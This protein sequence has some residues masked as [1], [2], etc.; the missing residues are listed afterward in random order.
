MVF[1]GYMPSS[2]IAGS[3]G[4]SIFGTVLKSKASFAFH[5]RLKRMGNITLEA[6][7]P[8]LQNQ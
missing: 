7:A 4:S 3:Y 2:G 8:V 5:V 1:S 6:E